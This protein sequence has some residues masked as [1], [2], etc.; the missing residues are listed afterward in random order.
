MSMQTMGGA[1]ARD[2]S[3]N[4]CLQS[5]AM[6]PAAGVKMPA[7]PKAP[8]VQGVPKAYKVLRNVK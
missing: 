1:P 4:G 7:V 5:N 6:R 2:Q 8:R 3:V